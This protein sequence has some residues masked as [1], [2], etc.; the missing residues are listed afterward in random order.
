MKIKRTLPIKKNTKQE[1]SIKRTVPAIQEASEALVDK[2]DDL[3]I[4]RTVP[5]GGYPFVD[6]G[7]TYGEI[8]YPLNY[9]PMGGFMP[10]P[11]H[12]CVRKNVIKYNSDKMPWIDNT[13]CESACFG[14]FCQRRKNYKANSYEERRKES[15]RLEAF[16]QIARID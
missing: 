10:Y 16:S 15:K 5:I 3:I 13:I 14:N 7:A 11:P 2:E 4:K 6:I 9:F 8:I 1:V 12:D